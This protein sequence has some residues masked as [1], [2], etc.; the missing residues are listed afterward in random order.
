MLTNALLLFCLRSRITAAAFASMVRVNFSTL[1]ILPAKALL[2]ASRHRQPISSSRSSGRFAP[3][4][5]TAASFTA[6]AGAVRNDL[7]RPR[8]SAM[9]TN[10]LLLFCLRPHITAVAFAPMVRVNFSASHILPAK[11]LLSASRRRPPVSSSHSSEQ[12][13]PAV[14]PRILPP[15]E[16]GLELR[17]D[18]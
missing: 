6:F 13:A 15:P 12:F 1:H 16:I 14:R 17:A 9:L 11:A 5:R 2:S 8:H 7:A 3:I 10:A 4:F 18:L